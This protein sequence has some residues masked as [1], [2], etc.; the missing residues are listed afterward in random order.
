MIARIKLTPISL[1]V[2]SVV[3]FTGFGH[4]QEVDLI[5]SPN[6]VSGVRSIADQKGD[7]VTVTVIIENAP[8][9][10][11]AFG[12]DVVGCNDSLEYVQYT[13]GD[14]TKDWDFFDCNAI[15]SGKVRVGGFTNNN[16]IE[17]GKNGSVVS[18]QFRVVG[19]NYCPLEIKSIVD[20]MEAWQPSGSRFVYVHC[21]KGEGIKIRDESV[22]DTG[23]VAIPILIENA[24]NE[25]DAFGFDVLFDD[26]LLTYRGYK[27]GDLTEEWDFLGVNPIEPGKV[28]A[29]GFSVKNI[30]ETG[31]TGRVVILEFELKSK[32]DDFTELIL[33]HL[34][35][36]V[37]EWS[38]CTGKLYRPCGRNDG[39]VNEDGELTPYDALRAFE[40]Y[41]GISDLDECQQDHADVSSPSEPKITPK[42]A[43]C[44]FEGYLGRLAPQYPLPCR[45]P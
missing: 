15:E 1:L 18:L 40:F 45:R 34:V 28:R 38:A 19:E 26:R 14:L 13:R 7:M 6:P 8:N 9:E 11:D 2:L 33:H 16:K 27:R 21:N 24:P 4:A 29:G 41:L 37:A 36:D 42:D 25:V 22:S 39:D 43:L 23:A 35:D 3:L 20:D 5:L 12:F 44:L 10:V 30:I 32:L 31:T 17:E